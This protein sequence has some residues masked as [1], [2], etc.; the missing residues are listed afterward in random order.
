MN[1]GKCIGLALLIVSS[2]IYSG[3]T[4]EPTVI[5]S[6]GARYEENRAIKI[7][8]LNSTSNTNNISDVNNTGGIDNIKKTAEE[9]K[10]EQVERNIHQ[11]VKHR[12]SS[13]P[14]SSLYRGIKVANFNP[15]YLDVRPINKY[16]FL[17]TTSD[18]RQGIVNEKD[19]WLVEPVYRSLLI[20]SYW[21]KLG[22]LIP[23]M[24]DNKWGYITL[25]G[26]VVID[27]LYEEAQEFSEGLA[28]V[29]QGG[30]GG[31]INEEG[32]VVI[33]LKYNKVDRFYDG[34]A[35][36]DGGVLDKSGREIIPFGEIL[37]FEESNDI[38]SV[39]LGDGV[40][41]VR[42]KRGKEYYVNRDGKVIAEDG[43]RIRPMKFTLSEEN[44]AIDG[45][46]KVYACKDGHV[47]G[48]EDSSCETYI[49]SDGVEL[50]PRRYNG[51]DYYKEA[52][53]VCVRKGEWDVSKYGVTNFSKEPHEVIPLVYDY[54]GWISEGYI[55]AKKGDKYG[56]LDCEGREVIPFIYE[57]VQDFS[58]GIVIVTKGK[59]EGVI[60]GKGEEIIPC[61]YDSVHRPYEDNIL[62]ISEGEKRGIADYS[63]KILLP[64]IDLSLWLEMPVVK[65]GIIGVV[66][67][68]ES[69]YIDYEGNYI[70]PFGYTYIQDMGDNYYLAK[71]RKNYE[72]IRIVK[73]GDA[74]N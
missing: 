57:Q 2:Y 66:N 20:D 71:G 35:D 64:L 48:E 13:I 33:P 52:N 18:E 51:V 1:K 56:F 68:G 69:A 6:E 26:E 22:D 62:Y 74:I 24:K 11:I 58:E 70:I 42:D 7:S 50:Y 12:D 28:A 39:S 3:C 45:K 19:Q 38:N 60:N 32:K 72:L 63:G 46:F 55:R 10:A 41:S 53:L 4:K 36:V 34:M 54:L 47:E 67:G 73:S 25:K 65:E 59:Y 40:I 5:R 44:S 9:Q 8:N 14:F 27:F 15:T 23:A 43:G 30:K 21:Y 16:I 49:D 29:K 37:D 31:Y 61:K 17:V